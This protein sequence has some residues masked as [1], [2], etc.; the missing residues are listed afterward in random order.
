MS[1]QDFIRWL[2]SYFVDVDFTE[3]T[4]ARI[5]T[6]LDM[7]EAD[8]PTRTVVK[9]RDRTVERI[10]ERIVYVDRVSGTRIGKRCRINDRSILERQP[11]ELIAKEICDKYGVTQEQLKSV[12]RTRALVYCRKQFIEHALTIY[13]Y[14]LAELARFLNRDHSSILHLKN[15]YKD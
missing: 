8:K 4:I 9:W 15:K 13:P 7:V 12:T 11:L 1:K 10:V 2:K 14:T 6:M 5:G 3:T